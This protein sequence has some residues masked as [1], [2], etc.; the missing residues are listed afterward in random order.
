MGNSLDGRQNRAMVKMAATVGYG[1]SSRPGSARFCKSPFKPN[2]RHSPQGH[3]HIAEVA[4]TFQANTAALE[5]LVHFARYR[6]IEQHNKE[7]FDGNPN[8]AHA[9]PLS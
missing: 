7:N 1:T 4:H 5:E 8:P 2:R 6:T 9:I 3:P